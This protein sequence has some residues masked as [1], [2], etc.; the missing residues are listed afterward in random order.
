[1][2]RRYPDLSDQQRPAKELE[3]K[4]PS[5]KR[6]VVNQNQLLMRKNL[7]LLNV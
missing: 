6:G 4:N 7:V 3:N 1:M 2:R 5:L